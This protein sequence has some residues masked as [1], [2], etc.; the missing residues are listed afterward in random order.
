MNKQTFKE[1][2]Q[3]NK[4]Q[5]KKNREKR[6]GRINKNTESTVKDGITLDSSG[7]ARPDRGFGLQGP[8]IL[9]LH[10]AGIEMKLDTEHG[11]CVKKKG[12]HR[13]Y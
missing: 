5:I 2:K 13:K 6:K 8:A 10:K 11:V 3:T 4:N 1:T 7:L 9:T 12:Y